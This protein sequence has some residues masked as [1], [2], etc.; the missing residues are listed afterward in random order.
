MYFSIQVDDAQQ[1]EM[2]NGRSFGD[3]EN[4]CYEQY[5]DCLDVGGGGDKGCAAFLAVCLARC[6]IG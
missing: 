6:A 5:N 1:Q 3:C 4:L 2:A